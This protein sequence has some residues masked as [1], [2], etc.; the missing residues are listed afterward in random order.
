MEA[1]MEHFNT[2]NLPNVNLLSSGG[3]DIREVL[4]MNTNQ[5]TNDNYRELLEQKIRKQ[6]KRLCELQE[7]S[8]LC[9][10]RIKQIL[11]THPLPVQE[12]HLK[13]DMQGNDFTKTQEIQSSNLMKSFKFQV[14][15]LTNKLVYRDQEYSTLHKKYETLQNKY[16]NLIQESVPKSLLNSLNL[17]SNYNY[18]N[19]NVF[20][21]PERIPN[22]KM[23]EAYAK[24]LHSFKDI[25]REKEQILDSLRN[26]TIINE[27]QRNYIEI[28]KQTIESSLI[29]HG[30]GNL[31]NGQ[32]QYYQVSNKTTVSNID[33]VI[34]IVQLKSE[35][36][37][38]RK[39]FIQ[40][41]VLVNE[42][43]QEL[44]YT[45][46]TNNDMNLKKERI[47]ES[48]ENGI[49]ELEE[50]KEKVKSLELEKDYL[51]DELI[52]VRDYNDKILK[53]YE[54]SLEKNNEMEKYLEE[55]EKENEEL[56][57]KVE[58]NKIL[59]KKLAEY[60][61][62]FEKIT[63]DLDLL[64]N[65]KS[66]L[67]SSLNKTNEEV[68]K[69]KSEN[70]KMEEDNKKLHN[71]NKSNAEKISNLEKNVE[72]VTSKNNELTENLNNSLKMLSE[73]E[74]NLKSNLSQHE[75][76]TKEIEAK[77]S[78]LNELQSK[79]QVLEKDKEALFND[80]SKLLNEVSKIKLESEKM[81]DD[82]S[83]YTNNFN[84]LLAQYEATNKNFKNI[85]SMY[86]VVKVEKENLQR[87]LTIIKEKLEM[88]INTKGKE[89]QRMKVQFESFKKE[90]MEFENQWKLEYTKLKEDYDKKVETELLMRRDYNLLTRKYEEIVNDRNMIEMALREKDNYLGSLEYEL[91]NK[92]ISSTKNLDNVLHE[93]RM[94]I[95]SCLSLAS[96]FMQKY[97]A[98]N[99]Y[100]NNNK[101]NESLS[102]ENSDINNIL[103]NIRNLEDWIQMICSEL[104]KFYN[105]IQNDQD[106]DIKSLNKKIESKIKEIK[107]FKNDNKKLYDQVKKFQDEAIKFSFLQKENQFLDVI[108]KK[109]LKILP[110]KD[111][112]KCFTEMINLHD[113][114]INLDND[115]IKIE[116]RIEQLEKELKILI[117]E[118]NKNF[119]TEELAHNLQ[120]EIENLKGIVYDYDKKIREKKENMKYFE[121][122]IKIL[123]EKYSKDGM[124]LT[125][126][127]NVFKGNYIDMDYDS[128]KF[129]RHAEMNK[130]KTNQFNDN[131]DALITNNDHRMTFNNEEQNEMKYTGHPQM[132]QGASSGYYKRTNSITKLN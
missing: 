43:R 101:I 107:S 58:E 126:N 37:K 98:F 55:Y 131:Y 63:N 72:K 64:L 127:K 60:K 17:M 81:K 33:V 124:Q 128:R 40:S 52:E 119:N 93:V 105:K 30:L 79:I 100:N 110:Y 29:K 50:A 25:A 6:A 44:E 2:K 109:F 41:D 47:K 21:L 73:S 85:E 11:P 67:D 116:K 96:I 91:N 59:E 1:E 27:E 113:I 78:T 53:D 112:I 77:T 36:E 74:R 5:N 108:I 82:S 19:E 57:H 16:N 68:G 49:R 14:Q 34:D 122:E 92:K 120:G 23:R 84:K 42:L 90:K 103:L 95:H 83:E 115:K 71:L 35:V 8:S 88:E 132:L 86:N 66:K 38:L 130:N 121:N 7:Y 51:N 45:K 22:E 94:S 129:Y 28:L 118:N 111:M 97:S 18:L 65:E 70:K 15:D 46:E 20:P 76:N 106:S 89:S 87:E 9:E 69:F 13:N 48:L 62:N 117:H 80:N 3:N 31:I 104:E 54:S 99:V 26:E 102:C 10:K 56:K 12:A 123:E 32:K 39:D 61:N 24:L 125:L 114:I 4:E 75:A